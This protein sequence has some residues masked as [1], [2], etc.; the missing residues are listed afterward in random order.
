[1]SSLCFAFLSPAC[2]WAEEAVQHRAPWPV[3]I[4]VLPGGPSRTCVV[5]SYS[6]ALLFA[7]W[8]KQKAIWGCW[9]IKEL[10]LWVPDIP[11]HKFMWSCW[12]A[13][14]LFRSVHLWNT[15]IHTCMYNCIELVSLGIYTKHTDKHNKLPYRCSFTKLAWDIIL[16]LFML[17]LFMVNCEQAR[18]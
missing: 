11:L 6:P 16:F 4:P 13:I 14:A 1:M 18:K 10:F 8:S 2:H 12:R 5:T 3:K 15:H 17:I 9:E 7:Q